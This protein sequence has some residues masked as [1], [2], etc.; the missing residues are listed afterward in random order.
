M[1]RILWSGDGV[2]PTGFA[3]VNHNIIGNLDP[4]KYEVY[5]LAINYWG[6]P[7]EYNHKIYPA[8]SPKGL[9]LGDLY[10]FNRIQ[11]FVNKGIDIIFIL[12]DIWV[13]K[14]YL[15]VIK[16]TY[17]AANLEVPKVVVYFPVDGGSYEPDW[18]VDFDIV[19]KAVVYTEFGKAV[20]KEV[21]PDLE[22]EIIPHGAADRNSFYKVPKSRAKAVLFERNEEL[23]HGDTFIVLNANRNQP[24]KRLDLSLLAFA[25]FSAG[26]PLSVRYYHHAG[27]KDAGWEFVHLVHKFSKIDPDL[28]KRVIFTNLEEGVQRVS[29]SKLNLIYNVA[30]VGINTSLGEGWGLT[31]TEHAYLGV[32]QVVG[33]HSASAELFGDIGEVAKIA[34]TTYDEKHLTERY[35]VDPD[36]VASKLELL[37]YDRDYYNKVADAS[38]KKF[39]N[40]KYDWKV[41]AD[42]WANLFETL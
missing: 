1:K 18:F 19:S 21:M 32:P 12:N 7:H 11:E 16:Q 13:I 20:V 6:D 35:F 2:T 34:I 15:D 33:N 8:S 22:V 14:T 5:H 17:K 31:N 38:A 24:R 4:E 3:T 41:I 37:Y 39:S 30:D 42:T 25:K 10:G 9:Q 36:D 28:E 26:K 27:L 29:T 23:K 40:P